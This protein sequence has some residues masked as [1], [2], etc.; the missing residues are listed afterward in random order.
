MASSIPVVIIAYNN[1]TF[2]RSFVQQ[3]LR[4]TKKIIIIDNNSTYPAILEYYEMIQKELGEQIEVRRK[5]RN[6]GFT[7]VYEQE[8]NTLPDVFVLSDPDLE[9]NPE[10]PDDALDQLLALS[11]KYGRWKVGLAL[12]ISEPEKLI[13]H[14][15]YFSGKSIYEW[16]TQ[17]WQHPTPDPSYTLFSAPIDTTFCLINKRQH[18]T[19]NIR[20]A[21]NFT[22]KHLPWYQDYIRDNIPAEEQAYWRI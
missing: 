15:N 3:L 10:M 19:T 8:L 4:I 20:V 18:N 5:D 16:E 13:S 6:Y 12:D 11:N 21:G 17:F 9:L 22:C 7:V 1:L 14:T 2:V